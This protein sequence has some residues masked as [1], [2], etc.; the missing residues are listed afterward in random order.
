MG[1]NKNQ[2]SSVTEK[3]K[4]YLWQ[5]KNYNTHSHHALWCLIRHWWRRRRRCRFPC[6][7]KKK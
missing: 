3:I 5:E 4:I 1:K 6:W 2:N 7:Q